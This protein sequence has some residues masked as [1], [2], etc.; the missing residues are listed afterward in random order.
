MPAHVLFFFVTFAL[1]PILVVSWTQAEFDLY[2]LVEEVGGSFY[3][4]LELPDSADSG[5]VGN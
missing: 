1:L 3:D 2:D 4:F 5:E